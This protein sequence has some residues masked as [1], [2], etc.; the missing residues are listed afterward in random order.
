MMF[1]LSG[2]IVS[3]IIYLSVNLCVYKKLTIGDILL[4]AGLS[5]CSWYGMIA[6]ALLLIAIWMF[7]RV[8]YDKVVLKIK[9]KK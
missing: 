1:Y 8:D 9:D 2:L 4:S 7:T 5:L 3:L 6:I